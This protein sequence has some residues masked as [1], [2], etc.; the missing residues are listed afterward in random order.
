M[1]LNSA[2]QH[3]PKPQPANKII[4]IKCAWGESLGMGH[5]QR[6]TT[7]LWYL[8]QKDDISACL[9]MDA[10]P[11]FFPQNLLQYVRPEFDI[12][13]DLVIKDMRDSSAGEIRQ[14]KDIC[15]VLVIDDIGE[16]RSAA[17]SKIDLLPNP[18]I[19]DSENTAFRRD[20]FLY[21][22]NFVTSLRDLGNQKIE[23]SIDFSIYPI[24]SGRQENIDFL[25]SLLP[26][27]SSVA[28]LGGKAP[29]I[30]Q[31]GEK[32]EL[33]NKSYAEIILSTKIIISHFGISLYEGDIAGCKLVSINPSSYHDTLSE[34]EEDNLGLV[35]LGI[36]DKLN[37]DEASAK[38]ESLL[39]TTKFESIPPNEVYDKT[40][41][42][43]E[44]F[45]LFLKE[46]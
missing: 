35:N 20:I 19:R 10:A 32:H 43:L 8:N 42:N 21:G 11:D 37:K 16:G 28:V 29:C 22:Y 3:T 27:R 26:D 6:M 18:E 38:I 34:M 1:E 15:P 31:N 39:R 5:V 25:L 2:L 41:E 44:R 9:V 33:T 30:V 17:D 23:K 40:I 7:L 13:P 14:L 4:A 45:Y 24:N 46:L 12:K 36:K